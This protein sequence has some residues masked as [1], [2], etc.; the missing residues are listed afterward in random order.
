MARSKKVSW[1]KRYAQYTEAVVR[2]FVPSRG[3]VYLIYVKL[4]NG[5]WRKIYGGRTD[6]L[7]R[8]LLEHLAKGEKNECL[9]EHVTKF[10]CGFR[11]AEVHAED[12]RVGIECFLIR[13]FSLQNKCNDKDGE[14][15]PIEVNVP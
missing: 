13:T 6:D 11:F 3:G 4:E 10:V 7:Q 9:K 15:D 8:R 5:E 14:G 2:E 1:S 12:D